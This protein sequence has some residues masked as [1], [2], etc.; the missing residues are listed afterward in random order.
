MT[1]AAVEHDQ[2]K[3][4]S[5]S[6]NLDDPN[7]KI[8]VTRQ[9]VLVG[10]EAFKHAG[11]PVYK[12]GW[13]KYFLVEDADGTPMFNLS[14]WTISESGDRSRT[15]KS[16]SLTVEQF[17]RLSG[18]L[19]ADKADITETEAGEPSADG[20]TSPMWRLGDLVY[21]GWSKWDRTNLASVRRYRESKY[22]D[23]IPTKEGLSFG[24]KTYEA[25]KKLIFD[26][27]STASQF[28]V[29]SQ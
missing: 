13:D 14:E 27:V 11:H 21:F 22:G 24:L 23:L 4:K 5:G 17:S 25:L 12:I 20:R 18:L 7:P 29:S 15:A 26:L 2:R 10:T 6:S 19:M 8:T 16:I 9:R 1:Q 3:R 28:T